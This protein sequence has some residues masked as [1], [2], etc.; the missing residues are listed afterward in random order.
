MDVKS[1][2]KGELIEIFAKS[3][4]CFL[5]CIGWNKDKL[6]K[7]SGIDSQTIEY[8]QNG[9]VKLSTTQFVVLAGIIDNQL[10]NNSSLIK[11]LDTVNEKKYSNLFLK[12]Q[13]HSME[14]IAPG[15]SRRD[16]INKY[17]I[18]LWIEVT[19]NK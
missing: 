10:R 16:E 6:A 11:C 5:M 19:Q 17:I 18:D 2:S 1:I 14:Q 3:I 7:L 8:I 15:G 4:G 12:E 13:F 9:K